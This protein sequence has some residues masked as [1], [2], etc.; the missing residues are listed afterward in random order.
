MTTLKAP[1]CDVCLMSTSV[2]MAKATVECARRSAARGLKSS[3]GAAE[4]ALEP[5]AGASDNGL[6][7]LGNTTLE[8]TFTGASVLDLETADSFAIPSAD[9]LGETL[10]ELNSPCPWIAGELGAQACAMLSEIE[11]ASARGCVLSAVAHLVNKG[12]VTVN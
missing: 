8:L 5:R 2:E 12:C 10:E 9:G 1:E 6:P 11:V 7:V 3:L 4:L